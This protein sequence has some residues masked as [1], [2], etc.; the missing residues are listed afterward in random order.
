MQIVVKKNNLS[1]TSY[2]QKR[3]IYKKKLTKEP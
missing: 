2:N 1:L 3:K